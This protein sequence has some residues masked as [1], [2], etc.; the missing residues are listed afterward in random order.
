MGAPGGCS[1]VGLHGRVSLLEGLG[2]GLAAGVRREE[3]IV[4]WLA[5]APAEAGVGELARGDGVHGLAP[6]AAPGGV[7]VG[8][9]GG[10]RRGARPLA[11]AGEVE[12]GEAA[13]AGPHRRRPPHHVVADHALHRPP[14]Q[15]VLDLLHQLRH[16]PISPRRRLRRRHTRS[17]GAAARVGAGAACCCR[18][19]CAAAAGRR[20]GRPL[21]R[22]AA[23][24][25]AT[26]MIPPARATLLL[27]RSILR[28][29]IGEGRIGPMRSGAGRR[30]GAVGNIRAVERVAIRRGKKAPRRAS[31][32]AAVAAAAIG[33]GHRAAGSKPRVPESSVCGEMRWGARDE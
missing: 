28:G 8:R 4:G 29:R 24:L 33:G 19:C 7:R 30:R 14:R 25:A 11:D 23:A 21:L 3:E 31:A 1:V 15:L 9:V 17:A 22:R 12:D 2:A 5:A 18:C 10:G 13:A 32:A 6:G 20:S 27:L 26:P 16:R